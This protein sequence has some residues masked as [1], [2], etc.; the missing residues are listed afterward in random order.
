L[1]LSV[2]AD[3]SFASVKATPWIVNVDGTNIRQL[4]IDP[5]AN[6]LENT[7]INHPR[8]SPDGRWILVKYGGVIGGSIS[9][10]GVLGY[11]F[12]VPSD[13]VEV[14][15]SPFDDSIETTAIQIYSYWYAAFNES[16]DSTTNFDRWPDMDYDWTP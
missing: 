5:H 9:N 13:G 14:L 3:A 16:P 7:R 10:P 4:A 2:V 6:G 12:A 1:A 15:L 8:W 11:L